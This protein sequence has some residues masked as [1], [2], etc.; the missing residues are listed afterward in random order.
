MILIWASVRNV[1]TCRPDAKG[2]A[3]A[4][5]LCES[6]S[7]DA[8]HRGGGARSRDEGSVMGLDRRGVV[9]QQCYRSNPKGEDFCGQSETVLYSEARCVGSI[10]AGEG[11]PRIGGSRWRVDC[12][13]RTRFEEQSL[14]TLE[15][16]VVRQLLPARSAPGGHTEGW[17]TNEAARNSDGHCQLHLTAGR[18]WDGRRSAIH[19]THNVASA[20]KCSRNGV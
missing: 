10:Q 3:Q 16:D 4:N 8:G 15:S 11:K 13:V 20:L 18:L 9:V 5:S 19:F 2:E 12:G 1:G 6:Q 14:L 17:R 7:T